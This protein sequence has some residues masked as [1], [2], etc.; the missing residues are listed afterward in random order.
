MGNRLRAFCLATGLLRVP[1]TAAAGLQ[2]GEAATFKFSVGPVESGRA[3]MSVGKPTRKDGRTVVAVHGQAETAPWLQLLVRLND[4]YQLVLDAATL[5]PLQVLSVERGL[6]ER[7]IDAQLDGR[8]ADF[9]VEGSRE[10]GRHHRVLPTVTRDP[11]AQ[12]FALRAAPLRDGDRL[13]QD[14]LDGTALWHAQMSVHR[15]ERVHLDIDG[16]RAAARPAI[17]IDGTLTK[18]NDT[19][20]PMGQPQRHLTAWLSDDQTRILLRLEADTDLGRCSLELTRYFPR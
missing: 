13:E 19:G 10:A 14:V 3:R 4:D 15:G 12:L 1:D 18:I 5:L 17:R 7:R 2:P 6:R 20:R 9:T 16:E 11:L 8:V